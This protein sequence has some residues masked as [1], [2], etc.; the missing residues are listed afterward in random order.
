M[1]ERI[2]EKYGLPD[3]WVQSTPVA[4]A[5]HVFIGDAAGRL[6][7]F[8][9]QT[10]E[11]VWFHEPDNPTP[12][13]TMQVPQIVGDQLFISSSSLDPENPSRLYCYVSE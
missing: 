7:A 9:T 6:W 2:Q 8:E 4:T 12:H 10:D 1:A 11:P 5:K 13:V 3:V